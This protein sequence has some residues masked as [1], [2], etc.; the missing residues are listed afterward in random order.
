M[1]RVELEEKLNTCR[2]LTIRQWACALLLGRARTL[3]NPRRHKGSDRRESNGLVDLYGALG[4][5][6]LYSIV[7]SCPNSEKAVDYILNHIFLETGGK[8]VK[9]PDLLFIEGPLRIGIDAKTFNCKLKNRFF[10]IND[11]K[12]Q[13]LAGQCL[14]YM[15]L[16]CPLWARRA[17]ITSLIPYED[18]SSWRCEQ[19]RKNAEGK[20]GTP[21]R[22]LDIAEAM[23]LYTRSSYDINASRRD[24]HPQSKVWQ[25]ALQTGKGSVMAY[26]SELLPK[27]APYL[28]Q[29]QEN[30]RQTG[31][32]VTADRLPPMPAD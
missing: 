13:H 27:A 2:S 4:E 3:S 32:D 11:N 21:S 24:A 6:V 28:L 20:Q 23:R 12:H 30:L 9:G 16:I 29:A 10:A 26:L 17:C 25:A 31:I 14:G 15:G 19:L 7:R 8:G 18:V 5:L 1:T 22:N